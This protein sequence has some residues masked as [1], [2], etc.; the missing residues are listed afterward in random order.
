VDMTFYPVEVASASE[1]LLRQYNIA[2][3][4]LLYVGT[5]E[6]RKNVVGVIKAFAKL[7][8]EFPHALVLVGKRGWDSEAIF[9]T[10]ADLKLGHRVRHVGFVLEHAGLCDF[11]SAADALIYPTYYEGF[12]LPLAEAM[13]CGCPVVTS[14]AASAPEVVGNAGLTAPPDDIGAHANHLRAI[15]TDTA[16]RARLRERGF[17][18]VQKFSWATCAQATLAVYRR[19]A[20]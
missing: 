3:P 9:K 4:F 19:L 2:T 17:E 16:L 7:K 14:N 10:V 1:R 15:L 8:D 18:Q 6:P 12:G 11:Y 5:L 20:A 13:L